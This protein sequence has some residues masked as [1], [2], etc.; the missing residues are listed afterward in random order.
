MADIDFP[1]L[2]RRLE[3]LRVLS[4]VGVAVVCCGLIALAWYLTK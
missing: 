4:L 3:V 2:R 1:A